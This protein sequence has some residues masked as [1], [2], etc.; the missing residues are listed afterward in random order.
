MLDKK[1]TY[2]HVSGIPGVAYE[3]HQDD[4][5]N[6]LYNKLGLEVKINPDGV[7]AAVIEELPEDFVEEKEPEPVKKDDSGL[8][9]DG[10]SELTIHERMRITD[11]SSADYLDEDGIKSE[12]ESRNASYDKRMGRKKLIAILQHELGD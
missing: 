4:G 2:G 8:T 9:W 1:K 12:L 10:S 7:S 5:P 3:Q 6:K 11:E